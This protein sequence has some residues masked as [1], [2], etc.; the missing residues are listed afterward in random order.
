MP[1]L[2][3]SDILIQAVP[4]IGVLAAALVAE[5]ARANKERERNDDLERVYRSALREAAG[6]S[7][8][9]AGNGAK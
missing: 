8:E 5:R 4:V 9:E 3:I 6:L 7:P 1:E 2:L